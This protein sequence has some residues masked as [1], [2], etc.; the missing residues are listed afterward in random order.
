MKLIET[1]AFA[2]SIMGVSAAV[3][4]TF[5]FPLIAGGHV[6]M[7]FGWLIPC[8]FVLCIAA[9]LSELTSSM[10]TSAGLYYFA[11]KLAPA[12]YS[13]LACWITGWS[14]VT[15]QVALVCS[16]DFTC[17]Q[18]IVTAIA[19]ATDGA[20]ILGA[21]P[22][23]GILIAILLTHAILC[24]SAT[25][26]VARLTL[27]YAFI[28][29]GTTVAAVVMLLVGTGDKKVSTKD[30]FTLFENN[31]GWKSD[32][33]AFMLAFTAPMWCLTGYDAAAHISEE[34]AGA[35]RSSPIAI[36]AGVGATEILGWIFLIAASFATTS[37]SELLA[38]DLPLP[39][40]QLFLNA[41][42]KQG[43][44]VIW[45]LMI[46]IQWVNGIS[47]GVDASRVVF[48]FARDNALPG[49]QW[50][51]QIN[52]YTQTPV[53]AVWLVMGLSAIL[54]IFGFSEAALAS[55]AGAT[56]VG[57]YSS[58][59]I[60]IFL[61]TAFKRDEFKPGPFSLG[62]WQKPLGIISVT[63]IAFVAVVLLFPST[64]TPTALD[65][66]YG[67][68]LV[69]AVFFIASATWIFSA[70]KWFTGPIPNISEDDPLFAEDIDL[71]RKEKAFHIQSSV[72]LVT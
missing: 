2:F 5:V 61:R 62:R 40:G 33:W 57:L 25:R 54:G 3:S 8:L 53:N 68:V 50:W 63:W 66:N 29:V 14:N 70:R 48:A 52:S 7:V 47:Q 35:A 44:L 46:S 27:V 72:E 36:L 67:V 18:M 9:C 17:A 56:V 20:V 13:A 49:S 19:V 15:G 28:Y 65:M 43:M 23:F 42:G 69:A 64:A 22:T 6:G 41:V 71:D 55:L 32:G 59:A 51:K 45:C 26:V 34:T 31:T 24:S 39:I 10:P 38:T 1:I 21:G 30:A 58:Y 11:A 12:K 60:P 37:V 4:T 16:I